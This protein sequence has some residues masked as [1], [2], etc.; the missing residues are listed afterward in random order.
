MVPAR[1]PMN[2]TLRR[3]LDRYWDALEIPP[4]RRERVEFQSRRYAAV[5]DFCRRLPPL[6]DRRVLDLGGGIGGLAASLHAVYGGTY[7]VADFAAPDAA[8]AARVGSFGIRAFYRC[9]LTAAAPL[10]S[11]AP[12]TYDVIL[13]VEVMEHLYRN[14]RLLL[15]AIRERLAPGGLLVLTTPNQARLRNR[16][17]LLR[18]ASIRDGD[19]FAGE[20]PADNGHVLEYTKRDVVAV[21]RR[22]GFRPIALEVRQNPP[23]PA[24]S[25]IHPESRALWRRLGGP[26]LDA[27]AFRGLELGDEIFG[28]FGAPT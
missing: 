23:S 13:F 10:A 26:L 20:G 16:L 4:E 12:G 22:E 15:R 14:P 21:A 9:D 19:V 3:E 5:V 27:E 7:D 25:S 28:L 17:Q 6:A 11:I 8:R 1:E 18:G 2:D 24:G